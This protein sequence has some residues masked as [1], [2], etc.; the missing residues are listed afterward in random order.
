MPKESQ[1]QIDLSE[2][3]L[4]EQK[5][6]EVNWAVVKNWILYIYNVLKHCT[7]VLCQNNKHQESTIS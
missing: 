4:N 6:K 5:W 1:I 3:K 7:S 2:S